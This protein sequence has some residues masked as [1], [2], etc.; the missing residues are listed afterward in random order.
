MV[1]LY[2]D[3]SAGS[4]TELVESVPYNL[5]GGFFNPVAFGQDIVT[6]GGDCDPCEDPDSSPTT[7]EAAHAGPSSLA[8]AEDVGLVGDALATI[9][10]VGG[11]TLNISAATEADGEVTGEIRIDD[12]VVRVEC[13]TPT[14][15]GSSSS[16][17]RSPLSPPA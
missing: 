15:T 14:S 3:D 8:S 1:T 11:Q 12:V 9:G 6:G 7:T 10:G 2:A 16:P 5:D 13:A 4:C 17:A